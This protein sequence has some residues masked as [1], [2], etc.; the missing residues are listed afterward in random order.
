MRC[1]DCKFW[2]SYSG[3]GVGI[4]QNEYAREHGAYKHTTI[5]FG[6]IFFKKLEDA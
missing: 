2:D 1:K 5:K 3:A 6:C 4:C